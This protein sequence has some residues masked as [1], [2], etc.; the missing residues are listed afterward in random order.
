[1]GDPLAPRL[2][3][4]LLQASRNDVTD[5]PLPLVEGALPDGLAG[6][7]FVVAPAATVAWGGRPRPGQ[8]PLLNGD[9]MICRVDF[10]DGGARATCRLARPPCQIAD[11]LTHGASFPLSL[12]QF[13]DAGIARLSPLVGARDFLN[14]AFVPFAPSGQA[15]RLLLTYDAGRPYEIDPQTLAVLGPMGAAA[16][17]ISEIFS[18][19]PFP[20]ILSCGHPFW[21]P[22]TGELFT[23]NYGRS[24]SSMGPHPERIG[25]LGERFWN[26][27]GGEPQSF[28]HLVRWNGEGALEHWQLLGP[29]GNE[30]QVTQSVHQVA[31]TRNWIVLFDTAFRVGFEQWFNDPFPGSHTTEELL[32]AL[33]AR[34]QNPYTSLWLVPRAALTKGSTDPSKPTPVAVTATTVPVEAAHLLADYDDTDGVVVHLAH[35]AASDLAEWVRP[36]DAVFYDRSPPRAGVEGMVAIGCMDVNRLG[37]YRI[38]GKTGAIKESRVVH[39]DRLTWAVALYAGRELPALAAAPE[40]LDSIFWSTAGFFPE[41]LTEFV[42]RLYADYPHRLTP[43][44]EIAAL[45]QEGGRPSTLI[46]ID[47]AEMRIADAYE[48]PAGTI[49]ASPQFVPRGDGGGATDGWI[50]SSV[51]TPARAELW[52]WDAARLC[53]GP[54]CKLD[55][56]ALGLGFSLHTAWLPS[57]GA[58]TSSYRIDLATDLGNRGAQQE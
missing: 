42:H 28:T 17:W 15:P 57:L 31:V 10:A 49:I 3:A 20:M 23:I 19:A 21:D 52:C 4:S 13:L 35:S 29:D 27:Q 2:P 41:L 36:Y 12:L 46:R 22:R 56:A 34:P 11:E 24:L 32:R 48:A 43:L 6:H 26:R 5:V 9:G 51:Y 47:S 44:A 33:L 1:M 50:V 54:I 7:W 8:P 53:A 45:A 37:R 18:T 55:A 40:R 58:R 25:W 16:E 14:T 30:V 38:D 39:D